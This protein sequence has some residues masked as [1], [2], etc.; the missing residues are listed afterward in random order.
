MHR[1]ILLT[2]LVYKS[3]HR[4]APPY[5][6]DDCQLIT[7]VGCQHLRSADVHRCTVSPP[8]TV[9]AQRYKFWGC[10]TTAVE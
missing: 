6:P 9:K 8:N 7:D 3:L 1:T 4:P 2:V 5:L 10:R